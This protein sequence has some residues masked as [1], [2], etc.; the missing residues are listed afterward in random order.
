MEL[1]LSGRKFGLGLPDFGK[2]PAD[3]PASLPGDLRN[4]CKADLLFSR[5]FNIIESGPVVNGEEGARKWAELGADVVV[6][7]RLS[8]SSQGQF[9]LRGQVYDAS[10]GRLVA[11]IP[12][13][14][15]PSDPAPA[16]HHLADEIVRYF[17]G[18]PG[19]AHTRIA[20]SN[21]MT[22]S[23]E[24]YLMDYDGRH[25][26]RL[27]T[28]GSIVLFP[29]FSPQG[30]RISFTSYVRDN[31]DLYFVDTDGANRRRISSQRGLNTS[32]N[33]APDGERLS[34]TLSMNGAPNIYL[35]DASGHVL[36][37][38]THEAGAATAA[39]FSPD[40]TKIA[41]TSDAPGYPQI[42]LMNSDGTGL[43]RLTTQG[44]CDSPRWCPTAPLIAY[45]KGEPGPYDIYVMDVGT[46]EERRLTQGDGANEN[47][48]WSPD[49][50]FILF[51]HRSGRKSELY[52]MGA[53]GS[54]PHPL[55]SNLPG[56]C[57]TPDW[58]P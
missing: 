53:D 31:P 28:D 11:D 41:F 22:G 47:P 36:R 35:I 45:T 14:G 23:K 48:A 21:D 44:H 43:T 34:V 9:E 57:F 19:I 51:T 7:T 13:P 12:S 39:A 38:M 54:N 56:R 49:G 3:L 55:I 4:I 33:W 17:S 32:A 37:Q 52:I 1:A 42:Y 8:A 10:T 27:T 46:K 24:L 15:F 26:R 5:L 2:A 40:G 58:G 16:A 6:S 30:D 29:K 25:L 20:F 50:N 18:R